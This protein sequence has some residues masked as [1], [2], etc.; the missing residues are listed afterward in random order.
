M[1][2]RRSQRRL[3]KRMAER[4]AASETFK[5]VSRRPHAGF[6]SGYP[7]CAECWR[8][9]GESGDQPDGGVREP[10]RPIEPVLSG[11]EAQA[12]PRDP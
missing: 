7:R 1:G 11:A 10:R 8:L 3:L 2:R 4:V 5:P 6:C 9:M 12:I